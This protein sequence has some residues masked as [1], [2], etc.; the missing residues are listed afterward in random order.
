MEKKFDAVKMV[1]DIRD[2]HY[3]A[4]KGKSHKE[5]ME[6]YRKKSESV[7]KAREPAPEY[8]PEK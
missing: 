8:G 2:K 4:M 1:R 3:S 6:Y 5:I 7:L